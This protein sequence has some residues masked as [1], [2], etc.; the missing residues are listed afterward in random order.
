[1]QSEERFIFEKKFEL[2]NVNKYAYMYLLEAYNIMAQ[3]RVNYILLSVENM[4]ST[5]V[6][7]ILL[8]QNLHAYIILIFCYS[9]KKSIGF[10]I[11]IYYKH[12]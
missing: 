7:L 8:T 12:L 9:E 11:F 3:Y 10:L 4:I 1:M 5:V 6:Q 2:E